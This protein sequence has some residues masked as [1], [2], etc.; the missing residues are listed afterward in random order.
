MGYSGGGHATAWANEGTLQQGGFALAGAW[1]PDDHVWLGAEAQRTQ[2]LLRLV[3]NPVL[4][5]MPRAI[6]AFLG[7]KM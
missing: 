3:P 7:G 4:D 1:T 2:E 5:S 6:K